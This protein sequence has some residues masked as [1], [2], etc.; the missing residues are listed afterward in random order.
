[1]RSPKGKLSLDLMCFDV[2]ATEC[3][4]E[5]KMN[6]ALKHVFFS[7]FRNRHIC[8]LSD[9]NVNKVICWDFFNPTV[10]FFINY[11]LFL[12]DSRI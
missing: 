5:K 2:S 8:S 3:V 9:S 7:D 6:S 11:K 10:F 4:D 1:M 12:V